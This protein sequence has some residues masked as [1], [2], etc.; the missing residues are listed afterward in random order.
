MS[1]FDVY[2]ELQ[3]SDLSN[4]NCHIPK[5]LYYLTNKEV[6]VLIFEENLCIWSLQLL[7]S[8]STSRRSYSNYKYLVPNIQ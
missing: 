4:L 5:K 3:T 7:W 2:T 8:I 6:L 1:I